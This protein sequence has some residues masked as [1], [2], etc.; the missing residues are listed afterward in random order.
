MLDAKTLIQNLTLK[1]TKQELY[2]ASVWIRHNLADTPK[3]IEKDAVRPIVKL[4]PIVSHYSVYFKKNVYSKVN[5]EQST[6]AIKKNSSVGNGS[7]G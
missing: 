3:K 6:S 5:G 1:S 4:F 2:D 7:R